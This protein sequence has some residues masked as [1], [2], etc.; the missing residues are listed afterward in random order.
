MNDWWSRSSTSWLFQNPND[1][2]QSTSSI[3][4]KTRF[5]FPL[6]TAFWWC[7]VRPAL[8]SSWRFLFLLYLVDSI[9]KIYP[10]SLCLHRDVLQVCWKEKITYLYFCSHRYTNPDHHLPALCPP[11]VGDNWL[12]IIRHYYGYYFHFKKTWRHT[13]QGH[14]REGIFWQMHTSCW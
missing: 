7:C 1:Q 12:V 13:V 9:L 2:K 3:S 5:F 6:F 8:T 14:R 11:W 4:E 10:W